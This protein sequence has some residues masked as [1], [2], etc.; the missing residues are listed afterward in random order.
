MNDINNI[1]LGL[2]NIVADNSEKYAYKI[3]FSYD[4]LVHNITET[5][6]MDLLNYYDVENED[7]LVYV[8]SKL[9][10]RLP[11]KAVLDAWKN[12]YNLP[13]REFQQ[14][15]LDT[16]CNSDERKIKKTILKNDFYGN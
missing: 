13:K 7:F 8:F 10:R 12:Q 9:L 1:C 11:E 2:Y 15:V 5:E 4:F 6:T 3:P 14:K 16:V